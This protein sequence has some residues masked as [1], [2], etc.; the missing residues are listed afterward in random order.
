MRVVS[1]KLFGIIYKESL[2]PQSNM[3]YLQGQRR[4]IYVVF[5]FYYEPAFLS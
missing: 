2:K 5:E 4:P 3:E 1:H